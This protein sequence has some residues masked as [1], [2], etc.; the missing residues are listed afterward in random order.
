MKKKILVIAAVIVLIIALFLLGCQKRMYARSLIR[1]IENHDQEKLET[2]LEKNGDINAKPYL[3]PVSRCIER[4]NYP[5]LLL[6]C[7]RGN[8]A[9][10][11]TLLQ[12]D[13]DPNLICSNRTALI[14]ACSSYNQNREEII[15]LLLAAGADTSYIDQYGNNAYDY[16]RI[17]CSGTHSTFE[18]SEDIAKLLE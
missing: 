5:P 17:T 1:A 7:E 16:Y 11:R 9:A 12:N 15:R 8:A 6:A 18:M 10:V 13:A 2:L 4:F 14:I 3:E